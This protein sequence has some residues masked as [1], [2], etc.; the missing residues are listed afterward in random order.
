MNI[1][2]TNDCPVASAKALPNNL[3]NKMIVESC[4]ILSTARFELDGHTDNDRS[5]V[6]YERSRIV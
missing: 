5:G 3:V 1:F 4:Q 6:D 2:A